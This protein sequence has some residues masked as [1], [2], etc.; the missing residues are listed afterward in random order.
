M[1]CT[2][3]Y[4]NDNSSF[5][6]EFSSDNEQDQITK[7]FIEC[8]LEDPSERQALDAFLVRGSEMDCPEIAVHHEQ[9]KSKPPCKFGHKC[10]YLKEGTCAFSH[11]VVVTPCRYGAGCMRKNTCKFSH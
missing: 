6:D 4:E 10:R 8:L 3:S 5:E 11:E 1:F 2:T 7:A 9:K